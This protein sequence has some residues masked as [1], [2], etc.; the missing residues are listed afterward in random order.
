MTSGSAP[1]PRRGGRP[2]GSC[3]RSSRT[4]TATRRRR[5]KGSSTSRPPRVARRASSRTATRR[6]RRSR[7]RPT[8]PDRLRPSR[9]DAAYEEENDRKRA[10]RRFTRV[11]YKLDG[12]GWT[13]DRRKHLFVVGADG[14]GERQLTDGDCENDTPAWSPDGQRIAFSSM[15][16]DRWDVDLHNELYVLDVDAEGAEPRRLTADDETGVLPAFSPDGSLVAYYHAP[17]DGTS[18]H[19]GQVAVVSAAG[20]ERRVLTASLDRNCQPY[21]TVREPAWEADRDRFRPG[22]ERQR[23]PLLGRVRRFGRARAG[24]RRRASDRSL[25]HR[26]RRPRL[27]REHAHASA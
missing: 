1:T 18:P 10:P 22:G 3:S 8:R 17:Y 20:G 11:S 2:T 15:R 5:R 12:V 24:R 26:R 6:S 27:H 9:A 23:P 13:G 25:R 7:G 4:A 16:G 14:S 21:P 19:H